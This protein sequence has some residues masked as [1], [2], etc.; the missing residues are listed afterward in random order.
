MKEQY[1][2]TEGEYVKRAI[3]EGRYIWFMYGTMLYRFD[4]NQNEWKKMAILPEAYGLGL[5]IDFNLIFNG[6]HIFVYSSLKNRCLILD[7]NGHME[8]EI[9]L[10]SENITFENRSYYLERFKDDVLC[11]PVFEG[12]I[13]WMR[14]NG[15]VEYFS[16]WRKQLDDILKSKK[17]KLKKVRFYE[18]VIKNEELII[19]VGCEDADRFCVIDT[20]KWDVKKVIETP[21]FGINHGTVFDGK[22]IWFQNSSDNGNRLIKMKLDNID[23]YNVWELPDIFENKIFFSSRN[24]AV[25]ISDRAGTYAA[26]INGRIEMLN[27]V[28]KTMLDIR[29]CEKTGKIL[30]Y[31]NGEFQ[32]FDVESAETIK[33][34]IPMTTD[35]EVFLNQILTYNSKD[36]RRR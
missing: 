34:P 12:D 9:C 16:E 23:D 11:I 8:N 15:K 36:R 17:T 1:L 29:C 13:I 22:Y 20:Q 10:N 14:S 28:R 21:F 26:I 6:K 5:K 7:E 32:L 33:I 18:S 35:L 25:Y 19:N 30:F 31:S 27:K 24:G 2:I 3:Y 4:V